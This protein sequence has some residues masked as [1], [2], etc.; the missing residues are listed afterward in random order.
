MMQWLLAT[1]FGEISLH[2]TSRK[3]MCGSFKSGNIVQIIIKAVF[4]ALILNS[5]S[6][7]EVWML[8]YRDIIYFSEGKWLSQSKML[9][10]LHD[11]QSSSSLN[12]KENLCQNLKMKNG[13]RV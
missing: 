11:L 2:H 13:S 3:F 10:R 9:K 7:L 4:S 1:Q 8:I 12:Q 6:S 5:G